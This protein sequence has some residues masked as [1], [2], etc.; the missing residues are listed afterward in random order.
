VKE[1][2]N[3]KNFRT[4]E[5]SIQFH[6]GCQKLKL[7]TVAKDQFDRAILSIVLNLAEGAAKPT[8][9]D[10]RK[11][12]FTALGSLR[13]VQALLDLFGPEDLIRKADSLAAHLYRLCHP[14][15]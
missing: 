2:K 5:L 12:Y 7:S 6:R 10:R 11:F 8:E 1:T 4:Y 14:N 3:M 9:R 15:R 13:E